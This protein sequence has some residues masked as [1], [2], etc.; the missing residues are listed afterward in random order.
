MVTLYI[1]KSRYLRY[2]SR[3]FQAIMTPLSVQYLGGGNTTRTPI[4]D[5]TFSSDL[6]IIE[7]EATPPEATKVRSSESDPLGPN[8]IEKFLAE[9][10]A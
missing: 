10:S 6:R 7:F 3:P 4:S 8:S 2:F 9:V 1:H 5:P